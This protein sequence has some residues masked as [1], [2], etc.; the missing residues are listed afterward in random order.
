M[1]YP[2]ITILYRYDSCD[3]Q[4]FF[5]NNDHFRERFIVR[6]RDVFEQVSFPRKSQLIEQ[7]IKNAI[8]SERHKIG[9]KLPPGRKLAELF[10]SLAYT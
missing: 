7:Q 6:K 1:V 3:I 9:E 2:S 5:I 8:L 10:G 4:I